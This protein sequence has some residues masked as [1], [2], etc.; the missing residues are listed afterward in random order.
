VWLKGRKVTTSLLFIWTLNKASSQYSWHTFMCFNHCLSH[1]WSNIR[2]VWIS[3]VPQRSLC[4]KMWSPACGAKQVE[5]LSS[6]VLG[7]EGRSLGGAPFKG[8]Q[9]PNSPS[10]CSQHHRVSSFAP[11]PTLHHGVLPGHRPKATVTWP[12]T[13][14]M[15][16]KKP[17]LPWNY[18]KYFVIVTEH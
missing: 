7:E 9:D 17:F 6:G 14:T 3:N 15:G 8:Y 18:L 5:P 1:L 16:Q 11:P 4:Y 13:K 2:K 12:W 10:V